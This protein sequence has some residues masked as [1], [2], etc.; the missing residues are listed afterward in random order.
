MFKVIKEEDDLEVYERFLESFKESDK[1]PVVEELLKEKEKSIESVIKI[2]KDS[3]QVQES[4]SISVQKVPDEYVS[5]LSNN[6][7]NVDKAKK[8]DNK[9]VYGESGE[10]LIDLRDDRRYKTVIIGDQTWMAENLNFKTN[11]SWCYKGKN[12]NCEKYGRLY[13]WDAAKMACPLGWHLPTDSEWKQLIEMAG[14]EKKGYLKLIK[15]GDWKFN[16]LLGGYRDTDGSFGLLE[17]SGSY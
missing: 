5:D 7:S 9:T 13:T 4:D 17:E 11:G 6:I 16:A 15:G 3:T 2:E 10:D 1:V 8:E 12:K 14:G